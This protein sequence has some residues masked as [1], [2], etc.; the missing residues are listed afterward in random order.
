MNPVSDITDEEV[1]SPGASE[2]AAERDSLEFSGVYLLTAES[3]GQEAV[4]GL[5]LVVDDRGVTV[6][7]PDGEVSAQLDW[8]QL[9]SV[10]ASGRM[11]TP[12]GRPGVILEVTTAS[13]T[14]R[15]VVPADEPGS[16][17]RDIAR[18]ATAGRSS[19]GTSRRFSRALVGVITA[20]IAAGVTLAILVAS[21]AVKF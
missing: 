18:L 4:P 20:I 6:R 14:H 11:R 13:K 15:F 1:T 3:E 5:G 17:E 19:H 10:T 21:G 9:S 12:V 8:A 7:K 2:P 16:I